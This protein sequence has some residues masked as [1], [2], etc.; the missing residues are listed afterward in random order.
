[1]E[2]AWEAWEAEWIWAVWA[3][4]ME[5]VW[6]VVMVVRMAG[7]EAA[8]PGLQPVNP[9]KSAIRVTDIEGLYEN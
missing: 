4:D 1:M 3:V 9:R 7:M 2:V 8:M 6:A 5:A